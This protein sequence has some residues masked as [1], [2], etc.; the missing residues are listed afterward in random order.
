MSYFH[1]TQV[2]G[3]HVKVTLTARGPSL[4]ALTMT[5]PPG[6]FFISPQGDKHV[7]DDDDG[8]KDNSDNSEIVFVNPDISNIQSL[9]RESMTLVMIW[10]RGEA[11]FLI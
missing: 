11:L 2:D 3:A 9:Q 6:A 5:A 7:S 4:I 1:L 10:K 8:E